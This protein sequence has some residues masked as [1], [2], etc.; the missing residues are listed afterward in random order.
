MGIV[1][2]GVAV[3]ATSAGSERRGIHSPKRKRIDSITLWR[4][5]RPVCGTWTSQSAS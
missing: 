3:G 5:M 2:S 1:R 4:R